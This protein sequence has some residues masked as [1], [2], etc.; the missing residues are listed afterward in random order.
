MVSH[1]AHATHVPCLHY[2]ETILPSL[3]QRLQAPVG[4]ASTCTQMTHGTDRILCVIWWRCMDVLLRGMSC[5]GSCL[6][7]AQAV[8]EAEL[9]AQ[10]AYVDRHSEVDRSHFKTFWPCTQ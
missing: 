4:H 2:K 6:F 7:H 1:F 10:V 8:Q 3:V 5:F 9:T